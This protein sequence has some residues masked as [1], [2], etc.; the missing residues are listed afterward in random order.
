MRSQAV[1]DGSASSAEA[2]GEGKH[3]LLRKAKVS[4]TC[5]TCCR[6]QI[7]SHL[8]VDENALSLEGRLLWDFELS[9]ALGMLYEK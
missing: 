8:R 6:K 4:N 5:E 3:S 2:H 7:H 9:E 1:I